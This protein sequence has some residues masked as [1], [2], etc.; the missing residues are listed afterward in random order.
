[1]M[2]KIKRRR[3]F[4]SPDGDSP[5]A[6]RPELGFMLDD[7]EMLGRLA[8]L[9]GPERAEAIGREWD[10]LHGN[11]LGHLVDEAKE[12]YCRRMYNL[13]QFVKT[14]SLVGTDPV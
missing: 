9:Y 2:C 14:L 7:G 13:S 3:I 10:V 12:R 8:H 5:R 1:M 11:G 6:S 4:G